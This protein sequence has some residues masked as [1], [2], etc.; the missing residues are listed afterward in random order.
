MPAGGGEFIRVEADPRQLAHILAGAKAF[1]KKLATNIR[2]ELRKA[3][4]VAI[5]DMRGILGSGPVG[6]AIGQGIRMQVSTSASKTGVRIVSTGSALAAEKKPLVKA[7]NKGTFRHPVYGHRDRWVSQSGRPYFGVVYKHRDEI[8]AAVQ[9]AL[10]DA[11][12]A[13]K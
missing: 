11:V 12:E 4:D 13:I 8:M 9:K 1:D 3:G 2:R 10:D 7:F 6:G 5:N